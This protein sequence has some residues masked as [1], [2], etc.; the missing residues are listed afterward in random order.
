MSLARILTKTQKVTEIQN[1]DRF[2]AAVTHPTV[3]KRLAV[4]SR[5]VTDVTA[6][7]FR[8]GYYIYD[9]LCL[10]KLHLGQMIET[11]SRK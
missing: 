9:F 6:K 5:Y 1:G 10:G 8:N 3:T 2:F 11:L 7:P 4:T